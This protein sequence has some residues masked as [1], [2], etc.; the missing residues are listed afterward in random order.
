VATQATRFSRLVITLPR[1]VAE[2]Y[3]AALIDLGAGAVE[4]R[5]LLQPESSEL[6]VALP[7]DE[8]IEPWQVAVATLSEAFAEQLELP[9]G[10]FVLR[11][12][13]LEVDYHAGW[14]EHLTAVELTKTLWFAP[15]TKTETV[16]EG[17]N[18]LI[19]EPHPSFGDG[20]HPTT[21]LVAQAVEQ[22][23]LQHQGCSVLDVGT[24]NGVLSLV[25]ATHGAH[26]LGIDID[27][28]AR[29]AAQ[30]NVELNG[31][32]ERCRFALTP[33][34]SVLEQFDLVLANLEPRVQLDLSRA[35]AARVKPDGLLLLSGF[36]AE[37]SELISAPLHRLGFACTVALVAEGYQLLGF[38]QLERSR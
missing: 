16:P 33:I 28:S 38:E 5:D 23:C 34:E 27:V 3:G 35:L 36:L 20:S 29:D 10:A 8:P 31:L 21:R 11:V 6:L 37:Q 30:H 4:Q 15:A 32:G 2:P 19:F 9:A 13:K 17:N 14:L 26:C 12:E 22:Y 18:W 1:W 24:G 7:A 25:A